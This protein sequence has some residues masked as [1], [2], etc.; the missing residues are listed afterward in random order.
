MSVHFS[1]SHVSH[2]GCLP[3][4]RECT[5][6]PQESSESARYGTDAALYIVLKLTV[7]EIGD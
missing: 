1:L 3:L 6:I 7:R 5:I 4:A 2:T